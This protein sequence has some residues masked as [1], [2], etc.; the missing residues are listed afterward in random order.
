MLKTV[1]AEFW[2]ATARRSVFLVLT[3]LILLNA[4]LYVQNLYVEHSTFSADEAVDI[5]EDQDDDTVIVNISFAKR[6]NDQI[7]NSEKKMRMRLFSDE[8]QQRQAEREIQLLTKIRNIADEEVDDRGIRG[9]LQAPLLLLFMVVS[10]WL[11]LD[12]LFFEDQ[13]LHLSGLAR[14][15]RTGSTRVF[16]AKLFLLILFI[17]GTV[18]LYFGSL[19]LIG[20]A[21]GQL[22]EVSIQMVDGFDG[23]YLPYTGVQFIILIAAGLFLTL[24]MLGVFMLWLTLRFRKQTIAMAVLVIV[25]GIFLA[26]YHFISPNS[27][28]ILLRY[29]NPVAFLDPVSALNQLRFFNLFGRPTTFLE[30]WLVSVVFLSIVFTILAWM[31]ILHPLR[32]KQRRPLARRFVPRIRSKHQAT[33]ILV[34]QRGG[35]ILLLFIGLFSYRAIADRRERI[36]ML[37]TPYEAMRDYGGRLT[38]EKIAQID[39]R[40]MVEERLREEQ[41]QLLTVRSRDEAS[42]QRLFDINSQLER[43]PH[44]DG[45]TDMF[46]FL[47]ERMGTGKQWLLPENGFRWLFGVDTDAVQRRDFLMAGGIFVLFLAQ[48]YEFFFVGKRHDLIRCTKKGRDDFFRVLVGIVFGTSFVFSLIPELSRM[49]IVSSRYPLMHWS[50]PLSELAFLTSNWPLWFFFIV[51]LLLT[52]GVFF[53][54][55]L[56]VILWLLKASRDVALAAGVGV[57]LAIWILRET[58]LTAA[59][60]MTLMTIDIVRL[61]INTMI[62]VIS[63]IAISLGLLYVIRQK[64][65]LADEG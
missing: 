48:G 22:P 1:V 39:E 65:V 5:T 40:R 37:M 28:F 33:M 19:L 42:E 38:V 6:I 4:V 45:F 54:L 59:S 16:F 20:R 10:M 34:A 7:V 18:I 12:V 55:G 50:A 35:L 47:N 61:P 58:G 57:L 43:L 63:L 17:A 46:R 30:L 23:V 25:F 3:V 62:K 8:W 56:I 53:M 44:K 49:I 21:F 31:A 24:F 13:R 51:R 60:Y 27:R 41:H 29:L 9:I 52:T 36:D 26:L 14:T 15:T 11:L 64:L 32:P 2:K